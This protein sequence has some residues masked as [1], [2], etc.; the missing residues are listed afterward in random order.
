[1]KR[2][3]NIHLADTRGIKRCI[4]ALLIIPADLENQV[5]IGHSTAGMSNEK[6]SGKQVIVDQIPLRFENMQSTAGHIETLAAI[7]SEVDT[8][9]FGI[10]R[11]CG[12]TKIL[13][14]A[15]QL[16]A[17]DLLY[18]L[19][20]STSDPQS[21]RSVLLDTPP[22]KNSLDQRL[23]LAQALTRCIVFLH[24]AKILH[25]NISPKTIIVLRDVHTGM[26]QPYLVGFRGFRFQ[27][28][29]SMLA[30]DS[31][32]DS[33]LY[34]HRQRQNK[35][36]RPYRLQHDMYSLGV[37]LL[38]IGLWTSFLCYAEQD[39]VPTLHPSFGL[40]ST[41]VSKHFGSKARKVLIN[42]ARDELPSYMGRR[43]S[44]VVLS[45]LTAA[46]EGSQFMH[47]DV[48]K[49]DD[50]DEEKE[51][52]DGTA[53]GVLYIEKVCFGGF[54]LIHELTSADRE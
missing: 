19:P 42:K 32:W 12:V 14:T 54:P 2:V 26:L 8:K 5:S 21:L 39:A 18:R 28:G 22:T 37:C 50:S 43:Y 6:R 45:C 4:D 20:D 15:G 33:N 41:L 7:L 25:K 10:L 52:D 29:L 40:E 49:E 13:S 46:D 17:Y 1:M 38:E 24:S 16:R 51:K 23:L 34:R 27:R 9:V 48:D 47:E 31:R 30:S 11:C 36:D 44:N 53:I 3:R 35:P